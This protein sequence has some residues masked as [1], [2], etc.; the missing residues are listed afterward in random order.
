[1]LQKQVYG[2]ILSFMSFTIHKIQSSPICNLMNAIEA[3][4]FSC[5]HKITYW[6]R[7]WLFVIFNAVLCKCEESQGSIVQAL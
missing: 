6:I 1:M 2:Y 5:I 3:N 4:Y 7:L